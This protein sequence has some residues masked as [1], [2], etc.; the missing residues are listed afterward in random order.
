MRF[1]LG[2]AQRPKK[3]YPLATATET[4]EEDGRAVPA[5]I[6]E[7]MRDSHLPANVSPSQFTKH[8]NTFKVHVNP[9][10]EFPLN[11]SRMGKFVL[12]QLPEALQIEAR[13][14]KR[15]LE[16][17]DELR[18]PLVVIE[19]ALKLVEDAYVAP[20]VKKPLAAPAL[21]VSTAQGAPNAQQTALRDSSFTEPGGTGGTDATAM[22]KMIAGVIDKILKKKKGAKA[23]AF[24]KDEKSNKEKNNYFIIIISS[25][26]SRSR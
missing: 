5:S 6:Y 1:Q 25:S 4:V 8:I 18:S 26:N 16:R 7:K 22:H 12:S 9:F 2:D 17:D 20:A 14:L 15:D 13:A 21:N 3:N 11:G 24:L 23:F 10:I 19:K